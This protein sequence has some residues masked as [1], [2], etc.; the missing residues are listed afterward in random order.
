VVVE[1]GGETEEKILHEVAGPEAH[2]FCVSQLPQ[3]LLVA[4]MT[5]HVSRSLGTMGT[6]AAQAHEPI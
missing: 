5:H 1:H 2:Y 6:D 4:V 3:A